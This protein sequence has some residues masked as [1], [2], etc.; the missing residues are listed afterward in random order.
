M[1]FTLQ[2]IS[3]LLSGIFGLAS[4]YF[5]YKTVK[6]NKEYTELTQKY[7]EKRRDFDLYKL[8][9][10]IFDLVRKMLQIGFTPLEEVNDYQNFIKSYQ[11]TYE[12]KFLFDE[13][14]TNYIEEIYEKISGKR[15]LYV[16]IDS[17]SKLGQKPDKWDDWFGEIKEINSWL[18]KQLPEAN[19]KFQEYLNQTA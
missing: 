16:K 17:Y 10:D 18:E 4:I 6:I 2:L 7:E 12:S 14:I 9:K 3:L 1:E 8:R 13:D 15:M 5:A 19:K 11:A